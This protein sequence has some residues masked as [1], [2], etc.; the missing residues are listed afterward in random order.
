MPNIKNDTFRNIQVHTSNKLFV[1]LGLHLEN[2]IQAD[3]TNVSLT[4]LEGEVVVEVKN[5]NNITVHPGGS[6]AIRTKAFHKVH[7]VSPT[8]SCYMY[9]YMNHTS[10][11]F[12]EHDD[13]NKSMKQKPFAFLHEMQRRW[14][15][16]IQAAGIVEKSVIKV[17]HSMINRIKVA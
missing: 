11:S 8:P 13:E 1:F 12:D 15:N 6:V 10:L 3:L 5:Q 9:T 7:T 17:F 14:K 2:F 16:F 4:V